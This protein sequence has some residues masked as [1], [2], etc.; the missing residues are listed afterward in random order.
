MMN[1]ANGA[2]LTTY[3]IGRT[4][5]EAIKRGLKKI[6]AVEVHRTA[7]RPICVHNLGEA[8]LAS[9]AIAIE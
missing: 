1:S 7:T 8:G 9:Q 2:G 6:V 3:N 5:T 4:Q